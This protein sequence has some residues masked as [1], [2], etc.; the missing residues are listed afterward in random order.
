MQEAAMCELLHSLR[1]R[2]AVPKLQSRAHG[3]SAL[4]IGPR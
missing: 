3:I 1:W 4:L 2:S